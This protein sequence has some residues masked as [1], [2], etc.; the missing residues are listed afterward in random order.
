MHAVASRLEPLYEALR[1]DILSGDYLQIDEVPWRIADTPG[2]C[3]RGYAWQFRDCR[4]RSHELYFLYLNGSRAGEIP[5]AELLGFR[6][7]V[8]TDSYCVYDYFELQ[9]HVTLLSCMAHARRKFT[10]AQSS[11]P[12]LAAQAVERIGL[13]YAL[14]ADLKARGATPEQVPPNVRQRP[15]P[16][17]TPWKSG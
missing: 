1:R 13:L 5:R 9:D 3:R 2:K 14:E 11:H 16:S 12:Q 15:F 8:Q 4:P 10:E 6:G 7:A 17:W